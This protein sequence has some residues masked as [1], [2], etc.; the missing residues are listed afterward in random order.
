M[1]MVLFLLE[2]SMLATLICIYFALFTICPESQVQQ[3]YKCIKPDDWDNF[4]SVMRW[5]FVWGMGA[6]LCANI[7]GIATALTFLMYGPDAL[8]SSMMFDDTQSENQERQQEEAYMSV[9]P[10][11]AEGEGVAQA[12]AWF[13]YPTQHERAYPGW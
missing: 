2:T 3:S 7:L 13:A 5:V 9:P 11:P 6:V 1:T 12:R 4:A 8:Q 10:A